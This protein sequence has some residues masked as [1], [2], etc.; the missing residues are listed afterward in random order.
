[1]AA[2]NGVLGW[3]DAS[4]Q[5]EVPVN[6]LRW[7]FMTWALWGWTLGLV[8]LAILLTALSAAGCDG[9]EEDCTLA[10]GVAGAIWFGLSFC[11]WFVGFIVLSIL[12]F[13]TR[14]QPR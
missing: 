2:P 12:W 13:M 7:R 9:T 3:R 10:V 8:G 14:P 4:P 6:P 5:Q 1:M 11:L